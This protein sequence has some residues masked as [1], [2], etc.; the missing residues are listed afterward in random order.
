M[1]N[2]TRLRSQVIIFINFVIIFSIGKYS[3]MSSP[4]VRGFFSVMNKTNYNAHT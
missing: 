1:L 2:V 3:D 4:I